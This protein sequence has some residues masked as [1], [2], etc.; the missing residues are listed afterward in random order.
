MVLMYTYI[1]TVSAHRLSLYIK[2]TW[3]STTSSHN[4]IFLVFSPSVLFF[5]LRFCLSSPDHDF[6]WCFLS[7]YSS[8]SIS[9]II[10]KFS[11]LS[12]NTF[13]STLFSLLHLIILF[14]FFGKNSCCFYL[15]F[16]IY[17]DKKFEEILF[18]TLGVINSYASS[19][20]HFGLFI[21]PCSILLPDESWPQLLLLSCRVFLCRCPS[22]Y[23][24]F[25]RRLLYLP[26]H[27]ASFLVLGSLHHILSI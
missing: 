20:L 8:I 21:L 24:K 7:L 5:F 16:L 10:Y 22:Y 3:Q 25:A 11:Y 12:H 27:I 1:S 23:C 17:S 4:L 18:S 15:T 13:T 9:A 2:Y 14:I 26:L 6:G 19:A